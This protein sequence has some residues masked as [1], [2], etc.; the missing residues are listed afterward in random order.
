MCLLLVRGG[1]EINLV[2]GIDYTASNG[3]PQDPR[4]LHALNPM[5]Y[6]QVRPQSTVGI[7]AFS[8]FRFAGDPVNQIVSIDTSAAER[9]AV[10]QSLG[11]FAWSSLSHTRIPGVLQLY[12]QSIYAIRLHGPTCFAPYALH[13]SLTTAA[14]C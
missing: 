11:Q 10:R 14:R 4:S 2:L 3:V 9:A 7:I 12:A 6:N 5:G 1:C 8:M 13:H